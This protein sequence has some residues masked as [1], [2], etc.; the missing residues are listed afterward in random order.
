MGEIKGEKM[1]ENKNQTQKPTNLGS[2][3][4]QRRKVTEI[5]ADI[6]RALKMSD[7]SLSTSDVARLTKSSFTTAHKRLRKLEFDD[8]VKCLPCGFG[9][10][11]KYWKFVR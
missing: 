5:E 7:T 10:K 11:W 9:G 8:R 6:I 2:K 3:K 4:R 1:V